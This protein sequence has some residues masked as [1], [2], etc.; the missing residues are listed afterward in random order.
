MGVCM[1]SQNRQ[2][3]LPKKNRQAPDRMGASFSFIQFLLR[4]DCWEKDTKSLSLLSPL[5]YYRV[6][7]TP[8][9]GKASQ[10]LKRLLLPEPIIYQSWYQAP[11]YHRI[12]GHTVV[13][14]DRTAK[15]SLRKQRWNW[16]EGGFWRSGKTAKAPRPRKIW[17]AIV[18][19]KCLRPKRC[20]SAHKDVA[21]TGF[22]NALA[23]RRFHETPMG[24]L[25]ICAL[26]LWNNLFVWS[27][28]SGDRRWRY[29]CS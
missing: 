16:G 17:Q 28:G 21:S 29:C 19:P 8:R 9:S 26:F 6:K 13:L 24:R 14:S 11:S 27:T 18:P 22:S 4:H 15:V 3:F 7:I 1:L 12:R 20:V 10:L 5:K 25:W 2:S 23:T